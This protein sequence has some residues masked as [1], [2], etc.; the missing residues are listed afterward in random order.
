MAVLTMR[1]DRQLVATRG[2]GF[3][4][5]R[6]LCGGPTCQPLR[7]V[8]PAFF[9]ELSTTALVELSHCHDRADLEYR[10][11]HG[12]QAPPVLHEVEGRPVLA[13]AEGAG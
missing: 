7:L 5:I 11:L 8:A 2:N 6:A 1:S 10:R 12:S 4:L 13:C 3:G 9:H